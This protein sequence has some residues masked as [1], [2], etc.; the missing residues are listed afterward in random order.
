[1]QTVSRSNFTTVKTEGAILPADLLQRIADGDLDGLQPEQYHLAANERPN[2]AI[3]RSWNRCLAVWRSFDQQ[4]RSLDATDTGVSLTRER[5]LLILFQELGY[6]RLPFQRRI[7][8]D[9]GATY[10]ISHLWGNTPIHLVSFRQELD[11]RDP[12]I[13]RSPHS[14]V[15]EFLNRSDDHL[16]GFVSNGLTLRLLR[17]NVSLTR[18]A[19]LEFDLESMMTGEVYADFSLLWLIC[20]QSR[21]EILGNRE[22]GVGGREDQQA[23]TPH[24]LPAIPSNCWLETWSQEAAAQGTRA[25]DTLRDGVQETIAALGRGFLA[26]PANADLRRQLQHGD[27][28][29]QDYYRQLLRLVYRLIFLFVAEDRD[30]L[31]VPEAGNRDKSLASHSLLPT[32][33]EIKER[34]LN[35]YSLS[36]LRRLAEARRGGP[37]PDLYRSLR[38]VFELLRQG[39][40]P[41]GLPAL[42]SFLFSERATPALDAIDLANTDLLN[43]IRALAF[44]I[45]GRVRRP[46]DYKNLGA[47]ELGSVYESLLELH[48]QLNIA[49]ATFEL[50]TAAGSERK[51]TGSYYTPSSLINS[52]LDS[53]LEP[54]VKAKLEEAR[55]LSKQGSRE[56]GK[57]SPTPHSPF[58]TPSNEEDNERATDSI[59]SRPEGVAGRDDPGGELLSSDTRVPQGRDVRDDLADS[60]SGQHRRGERPREPGRVYPVST[61]RPGFTQRVRDTS[62]PVGTGGAGEQGSHQSPAEPGRD[63][64]QNAEG[65]DPGAAKEGNEKQGVGSR[66]VGNRGKK[67]TPHSL[68]PYSPEE[69]AILN[70]KVID[71]ACGSGHFLIAAA[72]R[73]ALHLARLRTGDDEPGPAA[74]REAL[75]E[76]VRH[77]IHGVDINEMSVELCKV[78]LWM[79]TLDPGKPLGF[80]DANIRCGNSLIGATPALLRQGIPD[81]AF[82]PITGDDK[83]YCREWAKRNKK[84]RDQTMLTLEAQPWDRLGDLAAA[85]AQLDRMGSDTLAEVQ[86]Q[87]STYANLVRSTPYLYSRFWADAWCAAFVWPKKPETGGGFAYPLTEG[88]FRKIERNPFDVTPWMRDEI[89]RLRDQYQFFHWHL[90]F[91]HVFGVP[92]ADEGADNEQTGWN[93]GFDVV[94][95]N[96][97]WEKIN[98]KDEEFFAATYPEIANAPNKAKRKKMIDDL[99]TTDPVEY[100]RYFNT[101]AMHDRLSNF[102]R[103]SDRFPFTGV[104][105]INLYSV[106]AE[107]AI[108][109]VVSN[110]RAGLVIASGIATE[111]NN[112]TFFEELVKNQQLINVWD[113]E[114]RDGIFPGVHSQYKFAIFCAGGPDAGHEATDFAFYLSRVSQISENERHFSLSHKELAQINPNTRTCPTFRNRREAE[115]TKSIY[116]NTQAWCLYDSGEDWPGVP[117]TPFNMSNDSHLFIT[118][119]ELI[120]A[121]RLTTFGCGYLMDRYYLPLYES[122]LIQQFN[123]RY[124]TFLESSQQDI[125]NGNPIEVSVDDLKNPNVTIECRYW[126]ESEIQQTR[127][128]GKWFVSYRMI[129]NPLN[130]RTAIAAIIPN[131]PCSNSLTIFEKLSAQNSALLCVAINSF[132]Y[133]YVARQ[134]ISGRNFNHWIWKQMPVPSPDQVVNFEIAPTRHFISNLIIKRFLELTYTAWDLQP[135]AQ[136]CGY[137]GPPF[138]W[139]EERRFLLRC[140]LDAA[141]F[142]LYGITREDVDYIMDTFPIVKRKDEKAHGEYRTKRVILEIYDEMAEAQRSSQPYPTRLDPPP[143]DLRVAH[144]WDPAFGQPPEPGREWV[145]VDYTPATEPPAAIAETPATYAAAKD[146]PDAIQQTLTAVMPPSGETRPERLKR[147]KALGQDQSPLA[148]RELVAFLADEDSSVRWLASSSLVQRAGEDTVAAIAAFLTHAEPERANRAR[149]EALRILGLIADTAEEESVR[150]AAREIIE[151]G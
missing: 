30:L 117:K 98:L 89:E 79:E 149:P 13:N 97:P 99:Q 9:D 63:P 55:E 145:E 14:L 151:R 17:D 77:C 148:T 50:A 12:A 33:S 43:A 110:G 133:D 57:D 26:H 75:R 103:F 126:L 67:P 8:L 21:V 105:R 124:A 25:L 51:T 48:P 120:G 23:P 28:S 143:A 70:I 74:R 16:W 119:Q 2:E 140:E 84:E 125:D 27:L 19:Y 61:H 135:F 142:H 65:L 22:W 116:R 6:G 86:A 66:E 29:T 44:T 83:A 94:L 20:H 31:L 78:A 90:A 1:M 38:R 106:F 40:A 82:K 73:L 4:R 69:A 53:A 10:P 39:Y 96:P 54:V 121:G 122:K 144:P 129:T 41:L 93:G 81:A 127:Y 88:L 146:S 11:R 108:Q 102:F 132:V 139:D 141:Y 49:A 136:D 134:K 7:E 58:P 15:Q 85:M 56:W 104:S 24:S 131:R 111:D 107:L 76:V 109:N 3:N 5:W 47:E 60:T 87:E 45:E 64:G 113:F 101:Q 59:V 95:G 18:A 128:P 137:H 118:K 115:L 150:Q 92:S 62:D 72:N 52:L 32:P 42:G 37:H 147:A 114:N 100:Q 35:Y 46:V 91:P 130:E 34:Y 123:H 112:K 36:R 138:R 68:P 80:L 71:P